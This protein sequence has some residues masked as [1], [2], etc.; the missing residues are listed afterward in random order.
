MKLVIIK[1]NAGNVQSVNYALQRLNISATLTDDAD[2]I[3]SADK[4]IFPGVGAAAPAMN[5]LKEKN[6]DTLI[7]NIK[8]PFFGVCLGMQ[9]LCNH[10][11]EGDTKCLGVFGQNVE[12]FEGKE[13][14]PQMGWN[15]IYDLKSP[16][17]KDVDENVYMYF[18]HS[19]YTELSENT[20]AKTMY[21]TEYS[22]ALQKDNFY[23]VQFHPEK[24][25][26]AGEKILKNFV[27]L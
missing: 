19:Y 22:A 23:A 4:I 18:V 24:S 17:F 8:R 25:S 16:L 7:K 15:N 14:I 13:K 11:E 10:S 20:I 9:L 12:K 6:L 1:Y 5:Y 26:A 3:L 27:E 2:E 21:M